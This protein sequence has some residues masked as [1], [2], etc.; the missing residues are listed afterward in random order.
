MRWEE[1]QRL[2]TQILVV[3]FTV[4]IHYIILCWIT[5][6]INSATWL[7]CLVYK[8]THIQIIRL[9]L[10][11]NTKV[12]TAMTCQNWNPHNPNADIVWLWNLH[13]IYA[14]FTYL[15]CF[16]IN[17]LTSCMCLTVTMYTHEHKFKHHLNSQNYSI[18][19]LSYHSTVTM[20]CPTKARSSCIIPIFKSLF[21]VW[22]HRNLEKKL[23][24]L[25]LDLVIE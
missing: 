7:S 15:W 8:L 13:C 10:V 16:L 6:S 1:F 4:L 3:L 17:T 20:K 9:L 12:C 25:E 14:L 5:N 11:S 22:I 24:K 18:H 21:V 19:S 2:H 23:S